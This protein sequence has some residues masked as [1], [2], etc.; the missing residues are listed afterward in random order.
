MEKYTRIFVLAV[1]VLLLCP[2]AMGAAATGI[3]ADETIDAGENALLTGQLEEMAVDYVTKYVHT[4]YLYE[5][6][7]FET[8]TLLAVS[9]E[10]L[11]SAGITQLTTAE[12]TPATTTDLKANLQQ[13]ADVAE[14]YRHIWSAKGY[15]RE[16]LTISISE[17]SAQ[18]SGDSASVDLYALVSFQYSDF[19]EPT[20]RGS[21]YTIYF[22]R[23][24]TAWII[25]DVYSEELYHN[26]LTR[27]VF[28]CADAIQEFDARQV[29]TE[30]IVPA[31]TA[32]INN[33]SAS[34]T[35]IYYSYNP[36]NAIAYANTYALYKNANFYD[37]ASMGGNCQNF[38][39]QCVWAGLCGNN[40]AA[41]ISGKNYP[42]DASGTG[43][44]GCW[45]ENGSGGFDSGRSWI[46]CSGFQ[47]YIIANYA[48]PS[49][50]TLTGSWYTTETFSGISNQITSPAHLPGSVLH[51]RGGDGSDLGH[52]IFITSASSLDPDDI[53]YCANTSEARN[54]RLGAEET[55]VTNDVFLIIPIHFL[56]DTSCT[57]H[58]YAPMSTAPGGYSTKCSVCGRSDLRITA[59]MTAP[60]PV[61]TMW[62]ISGVTN[63][64]CY[65]MAIN[66]K[67]TDGTNIWYEFSN[68][69]TATF[70]YTFKV[71]GLYTITIAARD[72]NPDV[73]STSNGTNRVFTVRVY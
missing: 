22:T 19:T 67:H 53:T 44:T 33:T 41:S 30:Q 5:T 12:A 39:S 11:A 18:I 34:S 32:T 36:R 6:E 63:Y 42:M 25:S 52:A 50:I 8:N 7:D 58:T 17:L 38:A 68:T 3:T 21:Q 60:I 40:Q 14:Y 66:I 45:Y 57:T 56:V 27:D 2:W 37:Y 16:D 15:V 13:F 43:N 47:N 54:E 65:R 71:T 64:D 73:D 9:D 1:A 10:A 29:Q 4:A 48:N 46:T 70:P 69:D 35:S 59:N 61:G 28:D 49:D 26:G 55:Y 72:T 62:T 23:I 20:F 24:D 31:E 51:V